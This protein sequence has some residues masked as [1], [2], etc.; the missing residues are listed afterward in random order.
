[1]MINWSSFGFV[2]SGK[3]PF[4][5]GNHFHLFMCCDILWTTTT[6]ISSPH[7]KIGYN[8]LWRLGNPIQGHLGVL[9][10]FLVRLQIESKLHSGPE[11]VQR[12]QEIFYF[13]NGQESNGI[14][15]IADVFT[16]RSRKTCFFIA[17]TMSKVFF[18]RGGHYDSMKGIPDIHDKQT[19]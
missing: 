3:S 9:S 17:N 1:M 15:F 14:S 12:L 6:Y 11:A 10:W 19:C 13:R 2:D 7:E 16:N 4:S 18:Y 5:I 8:L